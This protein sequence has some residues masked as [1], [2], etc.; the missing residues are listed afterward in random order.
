[1]AYVPELRDYK[2]FYIQAEGDATAIDT[3]SEWGLV[4][5]TN[6]YV[7]LP[8]PK[9]PYSNDF[10][11]EDGE[12]EYVAEMHYEPLT[13][14]VEF[15][16]TARS[17][18]DTTAAAALNAQLRGFFEHVRAG[19]FMTYDSYTGVG[20]RKVRYAGCD[21]DGAEFRARDGWAYAFV[22]V[23]FK[24]NDPVTRMIMSGGSITEAE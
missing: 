16:V 21:N 12:D 2:P 15:Y 19:E 17:D 13:F 3:A 4:A 23:E 9:S 8:V 1:M 11:D 24:A 10:K 5:K 14:K 20:F 18:G 22:E 6:P 7:G